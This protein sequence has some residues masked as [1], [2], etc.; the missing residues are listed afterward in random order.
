MDMNDYSR[1]GGGRR[2]MFA[3]LVDGDT[4]VGAEVSDVG[5]NG[6]TGSEPCSPVG[7]AL[8]C[9]N[10]EAVGAM[11]PATG[12]VVVSADGGWYLAHHASAYHLGCT[13]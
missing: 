5:A 6:M 3:I 12:E 11:V 2:N 13:Q 4:I 10:G 1:G 7:I 9:D 8:S